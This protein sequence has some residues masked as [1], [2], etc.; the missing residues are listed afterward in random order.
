[1][2]VDYSGGRT[3][4]TYWRVF[5]MGRVNKWCMYMGGCVTRALIKISLFSN[6]NAS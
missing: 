5:N 1:M 6:K 4:G 3:S 2:T